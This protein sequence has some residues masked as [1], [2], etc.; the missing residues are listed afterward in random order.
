MA[1]GTC[2]SNNCYSIMGCVLQGFIQT[3]I[4]ASTIVWYG[5]Y[6]WWSVKPSTHLLLKL[7]LLTLSVPNREQKMKLVF[8]DVIGVICAYI[9]ISA[10]IQ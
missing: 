3:F 6:L 10:V 8:Y 7:P 5:F 1:L 4:A 9:C 2:A